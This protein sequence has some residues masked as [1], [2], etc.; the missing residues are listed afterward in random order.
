MNLVRDVLDVQL[1]DRRGRR[2]GKVD[3]LVLEI[4]DGKPPLVLALEIGGAALFRRLPGLLG[5][6]AV[7]LSGRFGANG[8]RP[9]RIPWAKVREAGGIQIA[10]D[11]DA[12]ETPALEWEK[13]VRTNVIGRIPG[14]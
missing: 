2:M 3:G 13:W 9:Y 4:R 7:A 14:A 6:A 5:R 10:L 8:G 11:L 12:D 1:V